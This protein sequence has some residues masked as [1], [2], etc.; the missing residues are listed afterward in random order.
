MQANDVCAAA[1]L[2]KEELLPMP[3]ARLPELS[4]SRPADVCGTGPR[5]LTGDRTNGKNACRYL[6]RS[7]VEH[8]G[9]K[10]DSY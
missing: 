4:L 5:A 10:A 1:G 9:L 7:L 8:K 6:N 2:S 3:I